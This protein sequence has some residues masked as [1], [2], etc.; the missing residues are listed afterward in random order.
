ML[1]KEGRPLLFFAATG[2]VLLL[3][4]LGIGAPVVL[5]F[6]HTGLVAKLPSAVLATGMVLLSSLTLVCGMVLDSVERGRKE[7]KRLAYLAI[8]PVPALDV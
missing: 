3:A 8:P 5:G 4:A 7:K 6:L 2:T 1:V